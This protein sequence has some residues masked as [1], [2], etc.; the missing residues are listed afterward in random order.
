MKKNFI[1]PKGVRFPNNDEIPN[2]DEKESIIKK[3][4]N[5]E[6]EVGYTISSTQNNHYKT[7]A[8]INISAPEIWDVFECLA[9]SLLTDSCAPILGLKDQE[10]A[11]QLYGSYSNRNDILEIFSEYKYELANDGFIQFGLIHQAKKITEEIFVYPSKHFAIW[12]N[13]EGI[14]REQMRYFDIPEHNELKFIDEYPRTTLSKY[15]NMRMNHQ[16]VV[17]ILKKRLSLFSK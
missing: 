10:K 13:Q 7:Y 16:E 17:D 5:V 2:N 12:T 3:Y 11:E 9:K 14:F 1:F 6:I 15:E 8:E 4:E